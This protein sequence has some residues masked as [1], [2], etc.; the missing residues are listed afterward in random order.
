MAAVVEAAGALYARL[1][2]ELHVPLERYHWT[3]P[4]GATKF[5][6]DQLRAMGFTDTADLADGIIIGVVMTLA[7]LLLTSLVFEPL[8]RKAMKH[9]YYLL[10]RDAKLDVFFR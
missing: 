8:G 6:P 9:K 4:P 2:Q 10:P 1:R 3:L 7:R 5:H